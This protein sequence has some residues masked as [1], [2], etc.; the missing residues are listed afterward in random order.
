MTAPG[1]GVAAGQRNGALHPTSVSTAQPVP[2][3]PR[4][5]PKAWSSSGDGKVLSDDYCAGSGECY[6]YPGHLQTQPSCPGGVL[7]QPC[8]FGCWIWGSWATTCLGGRGGKGGKTCWGWGG[9][10]DG[11]C[12]LHPRVGTQ[13]G[14]GML[15]GRQGEYFTGLQ[16][17][18]SWSRAPFYGVPVLPGHLPRP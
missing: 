11:S 7:A 9:I 12:L 3:F 4:A 15:Q 6:K 10:G 5:F 8:S 2:Q 17:K 16:C 1:G 13:S 14:A 18:Q